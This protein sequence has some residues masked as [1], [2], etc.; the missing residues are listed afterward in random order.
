M[1]SK[2]T[3]GITE[4]IRDLVGE[5]TTDFET[6][7]GACQEEFQDAKKDS[8]WT[9]LWEEKLRAGVPVRSVIRAGLRPKVKKLLREEKISSLKELKQKLDER[10][11]ACSNM[12]TLESYFW[13][14]RKELRE[15]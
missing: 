1:A 11:I 8:V 15:E 4:L 14:V 6:V 5:G 7:W 2:Y 13:D 3:R 9:I 10:G 12:K